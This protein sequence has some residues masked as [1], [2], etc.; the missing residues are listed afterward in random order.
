MRRYIRITIK[1][2][3]KTKS[4]NY[5]KTYVAAVNCQMTS[6]FTYYRFDIVKTGSKLEIIFNNQISAS[7]K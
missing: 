7:Q 3:P 1:L 2:L 4:A 5:P 6:Y